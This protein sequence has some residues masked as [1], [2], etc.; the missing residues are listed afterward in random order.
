VYGNISKVTESSR[1]VRAV[2]VEMMGAVAGV[3]VEVGG[4]REAVVEGVV[5]HQEGATVLFL[6][7]VAEAVEEAGVAQ[8]LRR[9][10]HR[11]Q[12]IPTTISMLRRRLHLFQHRAV[13]PVSP[14]PHRTHMPPK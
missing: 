6:P 3:A 2:A 10:L 12:M 1:A 5:V 7:V 14:S 9:L 11:P 4:E 8:E 13:A